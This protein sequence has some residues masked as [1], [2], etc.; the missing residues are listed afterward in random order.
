[1]ANADAPSHSHAHS[2]S[3][4]VVD[5]DRTSRDGPSTSGSSTQLSQLS[6]DGQNLDFEKVQA[7]EEGRSRPNGG[8]GWRF[9]DTLNTVLPERWRKR[10][11]NEH[12]PSAAAAGATAATA[13]SGK[14]SVGAMIRAIFNYPEPDIK[15]RKTA[16]LDALRGWAA[17]EVFLFHYSDDWVDGH[18]SWGAEPDNHSYMWWGAPFIRTWFS[19]GNA[20]VCLFF[21]I[22][23]YVLT[24][25]TLSLIRQRRHEEVLKSLSSA[26]MRRGIRLY[27]PVVVLTFSLMTLEFFHIFPHLVAVEPEDNYFLEIGRWF[28]YFTYQ[29][30]PL[31]YPDRWAELMNPFDGTISW[32]IPIEYY[33]SIITYVALLMTANITSFKVRSALF[34]LLIYMYTV[35]DE[36]YVVQFLVGAIYA[37]YQ[38]VSAEKR[39]AEEAEGVQRPAWRQHAKTAFCVCL[40]LFGFFLFGL[41]MVRFFDDNGAKG[42]VP[43]PGFDWFVTWPKYFGWYEGRQIDRYMQSIAADCVLVAVGEMVVFQRFFET[44]PLQYLGR[45]SFGLYLCHIWVRALFNDTF[46]P[47]CIW[48]V[49]LDP[50]VTVVDQ[51]PGLRFMVAYFLRILIYMP[52]NFIAAGLFERCLDRPSVN[53]ARRF[54]K[55]CLR[56]GTE[57]DDEKQGYELDTGVARRAQVQH[58]T[59][60][61][62]QNREDHDYVPV[63]TTTE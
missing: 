18:Y 43:R 31:R 59:V 60:E 28:T 40:A 23:G 9:R 50:S 62:R 33:G 39:A 61:T 3:V 11:W 55:L 7:L 58:E 4:E 32:T 34:G 27:T 30:M 20:A 35:K 8:S 25:R 17:W 44:R 12:L 14:H 38:L 54:E 63:A 57:S 37:E 21:A 41:P 48:A 1:M 46:N 56:Y 19:G 16:W 5:R 6:H 29:W 51:G 15:L 45:I 47:F 22:S 13:A 2:L 53:L 10:R 42:L 49:G 52:I 26:V 36:W 24:T